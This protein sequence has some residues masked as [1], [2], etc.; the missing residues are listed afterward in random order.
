MNHVFLAVF[1]LSP[2]KEA[3]EENGN[4]LSD[5]WGVDQCGSERKYMRKT[6][7]ELQT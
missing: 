1:L 2:N 5:V 6:T 7:Q 4:S 3:Q